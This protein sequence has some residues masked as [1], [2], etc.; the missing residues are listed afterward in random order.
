M[1]ERVP[2][3]KRFYIWVMVGVMGCGGREFSLMGNNC[4]SK[5][6]HLYTVILVWG[7]LLLLC[8]R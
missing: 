1:R 8:G 3:L 6:A 7:K 4:T 5:A 2:L